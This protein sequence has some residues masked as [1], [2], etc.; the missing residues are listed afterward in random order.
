MKKKRKRYPRTPI[1]TNE[2]TDLVINRFIDI[3][4]HFM[5]IVKTVIPLKIETN[6]G[7]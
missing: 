7:K 6:G 5:S 1:R 3:Y 2:E 4:E